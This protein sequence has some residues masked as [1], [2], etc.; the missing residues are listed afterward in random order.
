MQ[1]A[2][3]SGKTIQKNKL[4][5]CEAGQIKE[6]LTKMEKKKALILTIC[7]AVAILLSG[8]FIVIGILDAVERSQYQNTAMNTPVVVV[9]ALVFIAGVV[10]FVIGI[11]K[12]K[13]AK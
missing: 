12:M 13:S 11:K 3:N 4:P 7:G 10:A 5:P 1:R 6:G 8:V 9:L 2:D